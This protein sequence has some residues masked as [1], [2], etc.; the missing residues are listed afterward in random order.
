MW[1]PVYFCGTNIIMK[2]FYLII[3]VFALFFIGCSS[4]YRISDFPSKDKFYGDFNK[5]A[6]NKNMKVTLTNDSSF[7]A[8]GKTEISGDT[9]IITMNVQKEEKINIDVKKDIYLSLP[10]SK[11]KEISYKNHWLGIPF[12]FLDGLVIG[13]GIGIIVSKS[14]SNQTG[15]N[16]D[17]V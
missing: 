2:K 7:T 9:L 1:S 6:D 8:E 13:T 12:G 5:F 10:L 4:T 17:L 15:K 14:Q 3:A 16:T 11:I